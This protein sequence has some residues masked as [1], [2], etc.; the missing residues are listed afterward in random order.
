MAVSVDPILLCLDRPIQAKWRTS[1]ADPSELCLGSGLISHLVSVSSLVVH[2][3]ERLRAQQREA[4]RQAEHLFQT[5]LHQAFR[6][7]L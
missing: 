7:E 2:K 4:G 6:G 5:L 1:L 3:F